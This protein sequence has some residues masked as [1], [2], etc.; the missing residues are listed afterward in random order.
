MKVLIL[1]HFSRGDIQPF[2]ALAKTLQESGHEVTAGAPRTSSYLLR[3]HTARF[4]PF[5]DRT[6]KI[7]SDPGIRRL[8]SMGIPLQLI[9]KVQRERAGMLDDFALAADEMPDIVVHSAALPGH[10]I[11]ELLGVPAVPVC[12]HP[13][14][15][16]TESFANPFFP[17]QLPRRL[18]RAS[19]AW[20]RL[21]M[22]ML[23]PTT[24]LWRRQTLGLPRR[25]RHR[26]V[27][28]RPDGGPATVLQAF[29]AHVLPAPL[30][31]SEWVHTTGYWLLPVSADWTPSAEL[32]A[33]LQAGDPPVC[34]G[35]GS[36]ALTEPQRFARTVTDAVRL[37]GVRAI[38]VGGWGAVDPNELTDETLY[39]RE[40][41]LDWLFPRVAAIVHHGGNGTIGYGLA[42][43]RPQVVCPFSATDQDFYARRLHACGVSP[44]PQPYRHLTA[45]KLAQAIN[46]AVDEERLARRAR[47]IGDQVRAEEGT[48]T[49]VKILETLA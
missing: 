21:I 32:S 49:A 12:A 16:P 40:A 28:V 44:P 42:A 10:Q 38:V 26:N 6:K 24:G 22:R 48:T 33:F 3:P 43:G 45:E 25:R 5:E 37:A 17:Y 34:I 23:F 30:K 35:F 4:I 29:S 13:S 47:E 2:A 39:L 11:A 18:N 46:Q 1:T 19:Y 20:T 41:P 31:Y 9:P 27:L 36:M 15:V 14:W 8:H 7:V